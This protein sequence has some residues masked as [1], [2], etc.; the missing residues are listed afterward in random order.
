MKKIVIYLV[1]LFNLISFS[2]NRVSF[3]YDDAGNQIRRVMCINCNARLAQEKNQEE[4]KEIIYT[5]FQEDKIN[6][7]PNPVKEILFINWELI[8]ENNV[9]EI[10]VFNLSGQQVRKISDL[11]SLKNTEISFFDLP[12][13]TYILNIYQTNKQIK[14]IKILKQ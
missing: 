2:Q 5:Q 14:T 11:N 13:G 3:Q 8:N 9:S 10:V 4:Q 7:Y 12:T 1:L 6:Y